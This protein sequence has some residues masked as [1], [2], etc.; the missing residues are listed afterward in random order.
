MIAECMDD[1]EEF[2]EDGRLER[3]TGESDVKLALQKD[4]TTCLEQA[5]GAI[6]GGNLAE[7]HQAACRCAAALEIHLG[8]RL[9]V[10]LPN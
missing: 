4:A 2:M 7:A 10:R 9:T 3:L 1:Y 5:L 8:A 6:L